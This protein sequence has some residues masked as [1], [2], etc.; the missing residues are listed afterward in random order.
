MH[1]EEIVPFIPAK[2]YAQSQAFYQSLGFNMEYVSDE[3][4]LFKLGASTFFLYQHNNEAFADNLMFQLIVE[5]ID[6]AFQTINSA[7]K[8]ENVRFEPIKQERWGRVIYL[9]GPSGELWQVTELNL[10]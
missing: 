4:S 8:F 5:D 9:W 3:M 7:K 6:N 2:N 10:Q 1:V